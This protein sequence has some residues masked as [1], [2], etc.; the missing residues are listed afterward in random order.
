M[1]KWENGKKGKR[2]EKA[3]GEALIKACTSSYLINLEKHSI[4]PLVH[5][6][7]LYTL[8]S[9]RDISLGYCI[10]I[11]VCIS[12]YCCASRR[13]DYGCSTGM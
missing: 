3:T 5:F 2:K 13:V 12:V 6:A 9:V 7:I 8:N 10:Y 4:V 1:G 11:Y